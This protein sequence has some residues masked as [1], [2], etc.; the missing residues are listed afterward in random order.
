[1]VGARSLVVALVLLARVHG[2][3]DVDCAGMKLKALRQWL[4]ARGLRCDGCAEKADYVALCEQNKDAQP[5]E[6]AIK[7]DEGEPSRVRTPGAKKDADIDELLKN[8]K[9]MPGM[10]NIKMFTADD[11]KNIDVNNPDS[12]NSGKAA[13][14]AKQRARKAETAEERESAA[15]LR[16]ETREALIEFYKEYGL[17]DKIDGVDAAMDKWKGREERM[18]GAVRKKYADVVAA[19]DKERGGTKEEL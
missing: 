5:V 3:E 13:G 14:S 17:D 15:K 2:D 9:G 4:Q 16:E 11:L 19:K 12:W 6:T 18:I 7:N 10:E 1:M 8:M